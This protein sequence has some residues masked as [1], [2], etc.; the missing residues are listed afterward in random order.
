MGLW[1]DLGLVTILSQRFWYV[2]HGISDG[3][4]DNP[5]QYSSA[6]SKMR[7]PEVQEIDITQTQQAIGTVSY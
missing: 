7:K 5:H 6:Q 3:Q 2:A 1:I 4:I